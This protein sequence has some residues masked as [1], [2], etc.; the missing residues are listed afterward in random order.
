MIMLRNHLGIAGF[1]EYINRLLDGFDNARETAV[2][3][4]PSVPLARQVK[5]TSNL[6]NPLTE[7]ELLT[8]E[9]LAT[10]LTVPEIAEQLVVAPSTIRTYIKRI[11]S[12]LDVHSRIEAVNHGRSLNLIN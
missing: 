9:Y 2:D 11:Y 5:L 6:L 10:D 1:D 8:L 4:T 12:K 3:A 7:R